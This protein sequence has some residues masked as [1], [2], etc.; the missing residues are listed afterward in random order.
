[1]SMDDT[2]VQATRIPDM[3]ESGRCVYSDPDEGDI[4]IVQSDGRYFAVSAWCTHV[5]A[6]LHDANI[7]GQEIEC[8]LHGALFDL[9]NGRA[10]TPPAMKALKTYPVQVADDQIYIQIVRATS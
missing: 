7:T 1:M 5:R 4:L 9:E 2:W 8:P 10:L 3:Q 6:A